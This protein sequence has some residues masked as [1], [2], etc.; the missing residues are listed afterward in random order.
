MRNAR[1][2]IVFTTAALLLTACQKEEQQKASAPTTVK[3]VKVAEEQR[4]KVASVTGDISARVQSNL[5]FRVSG[6]IVERKVDVGAVV[7]AG[8]LLARID[9]EQQLADVAVA[10]ANLNSA[11]AQEVQARLAFQRQQSLFGTQVTTQAALDSA[12]ETL[13]TAQGS[14]A[15]AQAALDSARDALSY[16]ELRADADGII[17]AR[18]AEVG[19]VAQAAQSVFSLAHDGPR[20]A[21]FDVYESLYLNRKPE[22]RVTVSLIS[23]PSRKMVA[24]VREISPTIDTTTGT[25]RVKVGIDQSAGL[26]LGAPVVGSFQSGTFEQLELPWSALT[27]TLGKPS[28]WVVDPATSKVSSHPIEVASYQTGI[29][30]VS[31]GLKAGDMVVVE[32]LKFIRPGEKVAYEEMKQQ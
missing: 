14:V 19:Q 23:D 1:I 30:L 7:K 21:V 10:E 3:I 6:R 4:R 26:P 22:G 20:D 8:D 28:V 29:L 11:K 5:S 12:R 2:S 32:G 25:I 17:T 24:D 31:S 13:T 18:D 16:T 15:S 27:S 9:A